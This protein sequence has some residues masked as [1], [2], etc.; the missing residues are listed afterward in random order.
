FSDGDRTA[1][2]AHA[3]GELDDAAEGAFTVVRLAFH[4]RDLDPVELGS[5]GNFGGET[6]LADALFAADETGFAAGG[7]ETVQDAL[8]VV[9]FLIAAELGR[10]V[11]VGSGAVCFGDASSEQRGRYADVACGGSELLQVCVEYFECAHLA[12]VERGGFGKGQRRFFIERIEQEAAGGESFHGGPVGPLPL[13]GDGGDEDASEAGCDDVAFPL[14][15]FAEG[16]RKS[17]CVPRK[18]RT[19]HELRDAVGVC[20]A[21]RGE[22][23]AEVGLSGARGQCDVAAIRT[24][25]SAER[26]EPVKSLSEPVTGALRRCPRP[27]QLD[28]AMALDGPACLGH[29]QQRGGEEGFAGLCKA[30]DADRDDG[31]SESDQVD[32]VTRFRGVFFRPTK[33]LT[34]SSSRERHSYYTVIRFS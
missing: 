6:A 7:E 25:G 32:H 23:F 27:E 24:E 16:R 15:P 5:A 17:R 14:E 10:R 20:T 28:D 22:D 18:K 33:V 11:L 8:D 29:E 2:G 21:S 31:V 12:A 9:H 3:A 34:P 13:G 19:L 30:R 1:H 26:I 4:P